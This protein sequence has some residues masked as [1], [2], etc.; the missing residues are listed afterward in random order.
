MTDSS[1][2][3]ANDE[4]EPLPDRHTLAERLETQRTRVLQVMGFCDLVARA[5]RD[6]DPVT[7]LLPDGFSESL[8]SALD[9]ASKTLDDIGWRL[10]P[11]ELLLPATK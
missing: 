7:G 2:E 6:T 11:E 5:A 9:L 1:T 3:S 10:N 8:W 4:T